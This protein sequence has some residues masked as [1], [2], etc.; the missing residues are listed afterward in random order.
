MLFCKI[1]PTY[2]IQYGARGDKIIGHEHGIVVVFWFIYLF[3]PNLF[4]SQSLI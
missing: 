4:I 1:L 3:I 2:F